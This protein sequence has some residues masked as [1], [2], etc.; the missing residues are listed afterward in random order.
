MSQSEDYLDGLLNSINKVK[1]DVEQVQEKAEKK[2]QD[3]FNTRSKISPDE[4]FLT[5]SG[6]DVND[7]KKTTSHP[8]LRKAFSEDEFLRDFEEELMSDASDAFINAFE[9]EIDEEEIRFQ[10]TGEIPDYNNVVDA[11]LNNIDNVVNDAQNEEVIEREDDLSIQENEEIASESKT[12]ERDSLDDDLMSLFSDFNDENSELTNDALDNSESI[13]EEDSVNADDE[14]D[15]S[16]DGIDLGFDLDSEGDLDLN[17]EDESSDVMSEFAPDEMDEIDAAEFGEGDLDLSGD[18]L[19]LD[20]LLSDGDDDD[21]LDIQSLLN[22]DDEQLDIDEAVEDEEEAD[23]GKKKKK[24]KKKEKGEKTKSP[25]LEKL[26][27][28]IFGPDDEEE[29]EPVPEKQEI[30]TSMMSEEELAILANLEGE[31]PAEEPKSKKKEKKEK[32]KKEPKPKKE[33]K[34]KEPK[35]KKEKKPKP[36]DNSPKIPISVIAVFLSLSISIIG[37][38]LIGMNYMGIQRHMNQAEQDFSVGDYISA[39]EKLNGLNLKSEDDILMRNQSRT[40]ADL[41]QCQ[42][43]YEAFISAEL[44]DFALDSLIKG[45]GRYNKYKDDAVEYNISEQYDSYGQMLIDEASS[46]FGIS[47]EEAL[48]V[49]NQKNRHYYTIEL[50]K[51]LIRLG[52]ENNDS[53]T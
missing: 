31:P 13:L 53:D 46:S 50:R 26:K 12:D 21:L 34:P 1:T 28:I 42:K 8:N 6:I 36:V 2:Q 16:D 35:P 43:E 9:L 45:I 48:Y 19:G 51:I 33:K 44:Y 5:A 30:D 3:L 38:V 10:E 11:L 22:S 18:D 27:L 14:G 7:F 41:Q 20:D 40:L 4:D 47:E 17:L 39:Y 24:K 37:I 49:F 23:S 52:Y 29:A 15:E 25:I 32:P